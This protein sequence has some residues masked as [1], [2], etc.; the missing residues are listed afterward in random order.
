MSMGLT[1]LFPGMGDIQDTL[2]KYAGTTSS[3]TPQSGLEHAFL[4]EVEIKGYKGEY[5][6][7]RYTDVPLEEIATILQ[8]PNAFMIAHGNTAGWKP[9]WINAY[10]H[11]VYP[12]GVNTKT[13]QFKIAD[14]TKGVV[15]Y[16]RAEFEAG[17]KLINQNQYMFFR[18]IRK[19]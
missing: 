11:Y 9:P 18:V 1:K 7:K 8:D 3:G 12:I 4:K 5:T 13:G 6:E 19:G 14:P 10:G 17:I 16:S 2:K 15:N